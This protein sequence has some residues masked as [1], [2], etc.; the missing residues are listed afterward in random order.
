[1]P[2]E[3]YREMVKYYNRTEVVHDYFEDFKTSE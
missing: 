3:S 1:M 2:G